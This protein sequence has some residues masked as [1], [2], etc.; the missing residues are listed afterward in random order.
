VGNV[1]LSVL[2]KES[3]LMQQFLENA[4]EVKGEQPLS[5]SADGEI[6]CAMLP[7]RGEG[8]EKSDSF[9]RGNEQDRSPL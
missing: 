9:S 3:F 8:G 2:E 1:R 4:A 6:P 5:P 7:A